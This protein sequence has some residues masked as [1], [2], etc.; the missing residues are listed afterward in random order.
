[1]GFFK[2]IFR[3]IRKVLDKVVP[4]EIKPFLPYAAAA[5]PFLAP[6]TGIFGTMAGGA[7]LAGGANIA[8]QLAQEGADD[9]INLLSA[10]LA[11]GTGALSAPGAADTLR[12][13]TTKGG[14]DSL[15]IIGSD[16]RTALAN[17]NFLTKAADF[18]LGS[19]AKGAD[20]LG[21]AA[22]TLKS[23]G[24]NMETLKAA[25]IPFIQ[26]TGDA[27]AFEADVAMKEYERA[28]ADYNAQQGAL[29]TDA[30][31]REAIL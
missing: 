7:A 26:G 2:K 8:S 17:R 5:V 22:K 31:R 6:T 24:M 13:M 29:G 10:L 1:M 4:N 27:M 3:P 14:L 9:D 15:G 16:A 19:L 25:S 20:F 11:S 28:L 18:G 21:G 23:P 12:G 30:G